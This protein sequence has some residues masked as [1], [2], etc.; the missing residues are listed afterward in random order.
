MNITRSRTSVQKTPRNPRRT[1]TIQEGLRGTLLNLTA[2]HSTQ[3]RL[4]SPS[5]YLYTFASRNH[6]QWLCR[7]C[8]PMFIIAQYRPAANRRKS[9]TTLSQKE[10]L[11]PLELFGAR[12]GPLIVC[13]NDTSSF[14]P[15]T[16]Q[17]Y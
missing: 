8:Q 11:L 15:D 17:E 16:V 5:W 6:P 13:L 1:R 4:C 12:L 10:S 14:L 3:V 9:A 2:N 7:L